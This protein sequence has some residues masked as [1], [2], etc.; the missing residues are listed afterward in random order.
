[1]DCSLCWVCITAPST[2]PTTHTH[3]HSLFSLCN[4]RLVMV[5]PWS[6]LA[7]MSSWGTGIIKW[8]THVA[9]KYP[10]EKQHCLKGTRSLSRTYLT[11][12]SCPDFPSLGIPGLFLLAP[13]ALEL[14]CDR[15]GSISETAGK[16]PSLHQGLTAASVPVMCSTKGASFPLLLIREVLFEPWNGL[17]HAP[18]IWVTVYQLTAFSWYQQ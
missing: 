14:W 5:T 18:L 7:W 11:V 1:M 8:L 15:W 16:K 2:H 4:I 6:L 9:T 13:Q 12:N 3:T 10:Q 17:S